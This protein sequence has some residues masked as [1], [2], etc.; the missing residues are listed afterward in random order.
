M[1]PRINI[2]YDIEENGAIVT[3]SLPFSVG[4]IGDFVG[5]LSPYA[6][7]PF[8][9]RAFLP[10]NK[11]NLSD[12]MSQINPCVK[13]TI[14]HEENNHISEVPIDL[15]FNSLED[16]KPDSIIQQVPLLKQLWTLRQ[17]LKQL[18]VENITKQLPIDEDLKNITKSLNIEE[19]ADD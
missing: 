5:K 19:P 15:T 17:K 2:T 11:G 10:I 16:F 7:I 4:I 18:Q 8:Q 1:Q 14:D 6:S 9:D 13:F 3:K 12:V